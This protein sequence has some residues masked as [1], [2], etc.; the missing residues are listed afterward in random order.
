MKNQ[1][2]LWPTFKHLLYDDLNRLLDKTGPVNAILFSG[3]IAQGGQQDEY[4]QFAA[5]LIELRAQLA[6]FGPVPPLIAVPGNHD[7]LRP[8]EGGSLEAAM[9]QVPQDGKILEH[10]FN[11]QGEYLSKLRALFAPFVAWQEQAI[12]D[13]L[14]FAPSGRGLM[15]GDMVFELPFEGGV[16]GIATLNSAWLQLSAGSYLNRLHVD[17]R[18]LNA[19]TGN[20][21]EG[22]CRAKDVRLIVTHHPIN[23]LHPHSRTLW[24]AELAPAG[25][26]DLHLFGHMHEHAGQAVTRGGSPTLRQLQAASIFGLEKVD[27]QLVRAHGYSVGEVSARNGVRQISIWPRSL[28]TMPSGETRLVP[29]QEQGIGENNSFSWPLPEICQ[30]PSPRPVAAPVTISVDEVGKPDVR[31]AANIEKLRYHLQGGRAHLAVRRI[32]QQEARVVLGSQGML[33][34]GR[35]WGLGEDG[36]MWSVLA[37]NGEI[38][39]PVFRLDFERFTKRD[40]YLGEFHAELGCSFEQLCEYLASLPAAILIL[41]G[42]P[43]LGDGEVGTRPIEREIEELAQ[44][45]R[46][47]APN[48]C[49]ALRGR[50][51]LQHT[52][53]P[54]IEL[55]QFEEPDIADYVRAHEL[56]GEAYAR[57]EAVA[58]MWQH[59]GGSPARLDAMLRDLEVTSLDDLMRAEPDYGTDIVDA[60]VPP[61]LVGTLGELL[62]SGVPAW[63]RSYRLLEALTALPRGEQLDRMKRFLGVHPFFP[64]HA[65]E[66]ASR[67]LIETVQLSSIASGDAASI[68]K[69]LVVPR[70]VL[71]YV[72]NQMSPEHRREIDGLAMELYFGTK[73]RSGDIRRSPAGKRCLDPLCEPYEVLNACAL[74]ERAIVQARDDEDAVRLEAAIRV[75]CA[76][77]DVLYKGDH[78]LAA[79]QLC[80]RTIPLLSVEDYAQSIDALRYIFARSTRMLNRPEEAARAFQLIDTSHLSKSQRR[81][82]HLN[83]AL[84]CESTEDHLHAARW[85]AE[86][87]KGGKSDGLAI[88]AKSILAEQLSDPAARLTELATL[89]DRARKIK[90]FTAANNIALTR[91]DYEVGALDK[92]SAHLERVVGSADAAGD[93]N[94]GAKAIIRLTRLRQKA[95]LEQRG[96]QLSRLIRAYQ[97]LHNERGRQ[98]FNRA[99]E[100][101]WAAFNATGDHENMLR[102]FRHTSLIWRLRGDEALEDKFIDEIARFVQNGTFLPGLERELAYYRARAAAA[103]ER[104]LLLASGTGIAPLLGNGTNAV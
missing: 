97:H 11:P 74:V 96:D 80:E 24:N 37:E 62:R 51:R 26:F 47:F 36:F 33:W 82:M 27:G 68:A 8:Q 90:A 85:A 98:P 18:Q 64:N 104:Q 58:K 17:P 16:A 101:L 3:D 13:G 56:G 49:V 14:H 93:F 78:Y 12:L 28:R 67:G 66:L 9:R 10:V 79:T 103:R 54:I 77:G 89:E 41:D 69:T 32:E 4:D 55:H 6:A 86:V 23:W 40:R 43:A 71:D 44:I 20:D 72:R 34:I 60:G 92:A 48:A 84:I 35:D 94:N 65:R 1:D 5:I 57:P 99:H 21:P 42:I 100:T 83:L 39:Q 59:S 87:L 61:A 91:A 75:A 73:W 45:V 46:E 63:E 25:R 22:W 88:Q 2:W 7:L 31:A 50:P 15:P 76:F 30:S 70:V 38:E 81:N 95:G 19:A 29:D 52:R 53:M 102:L